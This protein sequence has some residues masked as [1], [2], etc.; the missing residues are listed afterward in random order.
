M[1]YLSEINMKKLITCLLSVFG[2]LSFNA[3]CDYTL[4]MIDSYGDGW[5]GFGN[6]LT[7]AVDIL[8]DGTPV[9][10]G[11]GL[12]FTAGTTADEI[13]SASSEKSTASPSNAILTS[14]L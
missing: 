7:C 2:F 1:K 10:T 9:A 3:Q 12:G 11:V 5:N 13:F 8:V 14:S 4:R 6:P